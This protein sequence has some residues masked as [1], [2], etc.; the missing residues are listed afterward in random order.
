MEAHATSAD[1]ARRAF[2]SA[3]GTDVKIQGSISALT[4]ETS[5]PREALAQYRQALHLAH[6]VH[7]PLDEARALEGIARCAA[8]AG[9]R[10]A[11]LAA[12][13]E[14][15]ALYQRIG[16]ATAGTAAAYLAALEAEDRNSDAFRTL[17]DVM[18]HQN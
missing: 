8:H 4:A 1:S 3:A 18:I 2:V 10:K 5:G 16:A 11:A 9:D 7:S 14:A 6:Q 15:V 12:L 17:A 13:R